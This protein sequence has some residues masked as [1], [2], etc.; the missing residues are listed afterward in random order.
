[1]ALEPKDLFDHA[2]RRADHFLDLYDLVHNSRQRSI[3]SDWKAN[4]I[5]L[6]RWPKNEKI[7]RIDGKDKK[8]LLILRE[9]AGLSRESFTH[10]Y[11][12]ELLRGAISATV[13]ALDRY[14]HE[15]VAKYFLKILNLPLES[16]SKEFRSISLPV[17]AVKRA[18]DKLRS[19]AAARPGNIIKEEVRKI[20]HRDFTFQTASNIQKAA[21]IL[22][23]KDFWRKVTVAMN[24]GSQKDITDKLNGIARRRNQIV[25]EADL[26]IQS[27]GREVKMRDISKQQALDAVVFMKDLVIGFDKVIQAEMA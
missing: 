12:S 2:M 1:M 26:I 5:S 10:D 3:R 9:S 22:G 4:F 19:D 24:N 16:Q 27:R 15:I 18:T 13:S 25:H 17:N 20:L 23:I 21:T 8:S 7:V 6:M 11:A 14:M